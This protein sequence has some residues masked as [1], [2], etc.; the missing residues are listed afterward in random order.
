MRP[1]PH[2]AERGAI[3]YKFFEII[4]IHTCISLKL[5]YT[6]DENKFFKNNFKEDFAK[7]I[8]KKIIL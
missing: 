2:F 1:V 5:F 6:E 3:F 7:L 8:L 4:L